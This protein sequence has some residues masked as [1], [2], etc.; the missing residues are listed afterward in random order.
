MAFTPVETIALIIIVVAAIKIFVLLMKPMAW[1]NF[2][3]KIYLTNP[4][5]TQVIYLV[6]AAI[7]L[8]YLLQEM[9]I[10]QILAVAAFMSLLIGVGL[11]PIMG[12][13]FK[14]YEGI[15]KRGNMWKDSWLYTLIWIIL[16]AWG[17][18]ELFF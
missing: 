15:I 6:L 1:M 17:V 5:L 4:K 9:T 7:V 10:V 14:K 13:L 16:L 2:A 12:D 11:M 3:K 18:K 8:Y